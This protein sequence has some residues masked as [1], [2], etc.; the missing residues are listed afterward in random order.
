LVPKPL[1]IGY[2]IPQFPGQTHIFF[3]RELQALE[4]RDVDVTVFSTRHPAPGLISHAWSEEAIARTTYLGAIKPLAAIA[5]L[6]RLP[7]RE[8]FAALK[9]GGVAFAKDLLIC[10][11]AAKLLVKECREKNISHVHVHSCGRAA[12]IAALAQRMGGVPYSLTLHGPLS[13][14][15]CGQNF[16]WRNAAFA[17]VITQKLIN[18]LPE[19]LGLDVPARL[20]VQSMGVDTEDFRRDAA[21]K[22]YSGSGPLRIFCC[23]RLNIVKGHQDLMKSVRLLVDQ[24]MDVQLEIAGEDDDGGSGYRAVL[25][26]LV[27]SLGLTQNVRLLGAI[28]AAE[29]KKK[30]NDADIFVLASWHEPL[31]VAYMEAMSV[32]V[33]TIGTNSGGVTELI[34]DG[35]NGLLVAPKDPN[36]LANAIQKLASD[37][38][39]AMRLSKQGRAKIVKS[40]RSE[41]GAEALLR[42]IRM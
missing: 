37:T 39:L 12:L 26:D 18:E 32:G 20:S 21:Y 5:T 42:E 9:Q 16:K 19:Q 40:F 31:G 2:L 34:D 23:A 27:I 25:N 41:L 29:V 10:A 1:K 11:A 28:S 38:D 30:L 15:G 22:P 8:L 6:A 24:G 36:A 33:P 4:A 7:K 35:V 14:Y 13:D 17:T 3:W